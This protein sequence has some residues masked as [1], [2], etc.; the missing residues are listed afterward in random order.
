MKSISLHLVL[1]IT[2]VVLATD[3]LLGIK[4]AESVGLAIGHA[5]MGAVIISNNYHIRICSRQ[6]TSII[7]KLNECRQEF[8]TI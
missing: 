7:C 8:I 1:F 6:A 3:T 5:V 4:T 2:G